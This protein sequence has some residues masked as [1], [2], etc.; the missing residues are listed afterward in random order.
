MKN[1]F[2]A[3]EKFVRLNLTG[4]VVELESYDADAG[5]ATIKYLGK[6]VTVRCGEISHVTPEEISKQQA[7]LNTPAQI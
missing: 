5:T 3:F 1:E 6:N 2:E 7:P 4:Q